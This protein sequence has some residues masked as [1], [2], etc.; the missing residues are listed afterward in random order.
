MDH[1]EGIGT[2]YLNADDVVRHRLVR[3]IIIAYE[4][5]DEENRLRRLAA[6]EKKLA[7][8]TQE[9]DAAIVN[10]EEKSDQ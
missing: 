2:V 7:P 4:K 10:N 8:P 5:L 6:D 9:M 1:L 3:E